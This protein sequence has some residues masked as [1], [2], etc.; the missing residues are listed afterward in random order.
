MHSMYTRVYIVFDP[1]CETVKEKFENP[2]SSQSMLVVVTVI[3]YVRLLS[4]IGKMKRII[5]NHRRRK[6]S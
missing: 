5:R 6:T 1:L 3:R 4:N 2:Q